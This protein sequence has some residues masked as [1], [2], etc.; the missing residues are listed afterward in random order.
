MAVNNAAV[1]KNWQ[2]ID[3]TQQ[4]PSKLI[5]LYLILVDF[6]LSQ[7]VID[8]LGGFSLVQD[9]LTKLLGGVG[10]YN[11]IRQ[12]LAHK[13]WKIEKTCLK[14]FYSKWSHKQFLFYH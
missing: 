8:E 9:S 14:K 7:K 5:L 2:A 11:K 4:Y 12:S 10:D 6:L 13:A 1:V 3:Y